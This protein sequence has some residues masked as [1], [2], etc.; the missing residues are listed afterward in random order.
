MSANADGAME[1]DGVLG[2]LRWLGA[3]IAHVRHKLRSNTVTNSR[4]NI[5]YHYDAGNAMYALFLDATMTYSSGITHC[6]P[7]R[8]RGPCA[9]T[10]PGADGTLGTFA[11]LQ[12]PLEGPYDAPCL[13]ADGGL[14]ANGPSADDLEESQLRKLDEVIA[15]AGLRPE[16]RVLEIG[17]G[18]GSMSLRM[19]QRIGCR[20]VGVTLST[21]QLTVAQAR[22]AAAG[23]GHLVDL[24]LQD[25]RHVEA[26]DGAGSYD[27]VVSIEMLEAV[28]HEHLPQ[29]FAAVARLLRAGGRA[30]VQVIAMRNDAYA[31]YCAGN[32]FIRE[33]IFPG[34]HLPSLAA[35][36]AVAAPV[37][38][39][40][41]ATIDIGPDYALTLREWRQRWLTRQA[42]ILA[43]GYSVQ[44]FRKYEFYFAYCEAAFEFGYIHDFIATFDRKDTTGRLAEAENKQATAAAPVSNGLWTTACFAAAAMA[45]AAVTA[46]V[47]ARKA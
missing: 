46:S 18:W 4:K 43:L 26:A 2:M 25:Y 30:V 8:E 27:R 1:S 41:A 32:D 36:D 12:W 40:R 45:I 9:D 6:A 11:R 19:A 15:R 16:H 20:V 42:D 5:S 24:R 13:S 17:C 3:K 37:G 34:G 22:V 14:A 47:V 28:G 39:Y 7:S 23:V 38:L 29:Y 31:R 10:V 44:F 33:H 21:E 35:M